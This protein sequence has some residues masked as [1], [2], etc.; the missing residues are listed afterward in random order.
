MASYEPRQKKQ[1]KTQKFQRRKG[2]LNTVGA[3]GKK[4]TIVGSND[5]GVGGVGTEL[6][7]KPLTANRSSTITTLG[8]E[9]IPQLTTV[10]GGFMTSLGE[11]SKEVLLPLSDN[12]FITAGVFN[13]QPLISVRQ[14]YLKAGDPTTL[15]AGEKGMSLTPEEWRTLKNV[16]FDKAIVDI[17]YEFFYGPTTPKPRMFH[18]G[19]LRYAVVQNI[20][21]QLTVG[22]WQYERQPTS[23]EPVRTQKGL[24]LTLQQWE[25]LGSKKET[26]DWII[27]AVAKGKS[28]LDLDVIEGIPI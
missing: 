19:N 25:A 6:P 8:A 7:A 12:V 11:N 18:L 4:S 21:K 13:D 10:N 27:D 22:L 16:L 15:E 9:P 20:D 3:F 23:N 2:A 24:T 14:F 5:S 17:F 1:K 26:V 28:P